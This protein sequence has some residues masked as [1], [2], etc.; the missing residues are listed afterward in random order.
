MIE[1]IKKIV[2]KLIR[3][4]Y[5]FDCFHAIGRRHIPVVSDCHVW[6]EREKRFEEPW[7]MQKNSE[8]DRGVAIFILQSAWP[9]ACYGH[10]SLE[11]TDGVIILIPLTNHVVDGIIHFRRHC[12][13]IILK[14]KGL[15]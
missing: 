15:I 10:M 13:V 6:M 4:P 9:V 7:L 1:N 14:F 8:V 3:E 2:L 5:H 11:K 12:I